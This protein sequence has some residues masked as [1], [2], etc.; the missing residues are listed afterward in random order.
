M[1]E[2]DFSQFDG[3]LGIYGWVGWQ[4]RRGLKRC[5]LLMLI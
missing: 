3:W 4:V 1:W 2:V 5:Q